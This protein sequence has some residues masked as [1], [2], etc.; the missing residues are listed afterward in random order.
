MLK[1]STLIQW[2]IE[3]T[4]LRDA[5]DY[6]IRSIDTCG[7]KDFCTG[8]HAGQLYRGCE[9]A[10]LFLDST[11]E[12]ILHSCEY[13]MNGGQWHSGRGDTKARLREAL[14]LAREN[15]R[16]TEALL[17]GAGTLAQRR[18]ALAGELAAAA[19]THERALAA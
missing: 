17:K 8:I 12:G 10:A 7:G 14:K 16:E 11:T 1:T 2:K 9:A 19:D 6:A 15:L 13:T 3:A 5:I 18:L 4:E